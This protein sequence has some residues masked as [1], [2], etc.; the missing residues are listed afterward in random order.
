MIYAN[1]EEDTKEVQQIF[2]GI[3]QSLAI[4]KLDIKIQAHTHA[5]QKQTTVYS[6]PIV[7]TFY[8]RVYLVILNHADTTKE[9]NQCKKNYYKQY[10]HY[11][12]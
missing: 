9:H 5:D 7:E 1:F 8:G 4:D 2:N 12:M 10:S 6:V 11:A 3:V